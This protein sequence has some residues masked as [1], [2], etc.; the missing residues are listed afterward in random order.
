MNQM[1]VG[2]HLARRNPKYVVVDRRIGTLMD[3]YRVGNITQMDFLSGVGHNF[4]QPK[5]RQLN[6]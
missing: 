6:N 3:R 2:Q 4:S 5:R 1:G